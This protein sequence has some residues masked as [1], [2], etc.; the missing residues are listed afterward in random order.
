[1][2][3]KRITIFTSLLFL[4]ITLS[5][6]LQAQV[7]ILQQGFDSTSGSHA[8][9]TWTVV[10]QIQNGGNAWTSQG[11]GND[12]IEGNYSCSGWSSCYDRT[13]NTY[14]ISGGAPI[15][16][17]TGT[18]IGYGTTNSSYFAI[19]DDYDA[20]DDS[21][22]GIYTPT[23]NVSSYHNVTLTFYWNN[24][25][26]SGSYIQV[27]YKSSGS[28]SSGT[29]FAEGTGTLGWH[30]ATM[31]L[32]ATT[33][34]V[35]FF[36]VSDYKYYAIGLDQIEIY[37]TPNCTLSASISSS[38]NVSPCYGSNNGA[39]T[40]S[41]SSGTTPYTYSWTPSSGVSGATTSSASSMPEGTYTCTVTDANGCVQTPTITIGGPTKV[42]G[43]ITA[44][45]NVGCN[46]ASTGSATVAGS[47]GTSPYTYSWSSGKGTN[48][49]A[50]GLSAGS[51]TVTITDAHSCTGSVVVAITQPNV[52]RDSVSSQTNILCH[53]NS[54]GSATIGVKGGTSP[55]SYS[56]APSGGT[57]ATANNL[58]AGSYTC[59]ITDANGCTGTQAVT[60]T[61]PSLALSASISS[62]NAPCNGENGNATVTASGGT[63]P[64]SYSWTSGRGTNSTASL[65]AGN[66]TVTVTDNNGCT[67]AQSVTISQPAVLNGYYTYSNICGSTNGSISI[68]DVTGGTPPYTYT[69]TPN[70]STTATASNLTAGTYSFALNDAN[71]CGPIP[72]SQTIVNATESVSI[73]STSSVT[74]YG[75]HNGSATASA[76]P[77]HNY[78][79]SP[80]GGNSSTAN[81]LGA[82]TYTVSSTSTGGCTTT[83]TVT[84]AQPDSFA[85][86]VYYTP[87]CGSTKGTIDVQ[88]TGGTTPYTYNYRP[89]VGS[90]D[91]VYN[92]TA[93][94]YTVTVND[95]NGCGP[96]GAV[97]DIRTGTVET[98][99]IASQSNDLCNGYSDGKATASAP[100]TNYYQWSN[101]TD[102][103]A[104]DSNLTA[105]TYT[106]TG[107]N[108]TGC[109]ASTTVTITQ[110]SA[111]SASTTYTNTCSGSSNGSAQ[112]SVSGGTPPYTYSW[113]T[114]PAQTTSTATALTAGTYS[115]TVKDHNNCTITASVTIS[116]NTV[117][118][119]TV[120]PTSVS[121]CNGSSASISASGANSYAWS[122]STS[123]NSTT[124]ATVSVYPGSSITYTVTGTNSDGCS[125]TQTVSVT[126]NSL[127]TLTVTPTSVSICTGS[128]T[129]LNVSGASTYSWSPS[130]SLNV[131]TGTTVTANPTISTTYTITGTGSNECVNTQTVSVIVNSI[132]TVSVTETASVVC[133]GSPDTLKASGATTYTWMPSTGLNAT[134]GATVIAHPTTSMTYTVTG[135][136]ANGC[137]N[138]ATVI[139]TVHPTPVVNADSSLVHLI[140]GG[141]T[142]ATGG[143]PPYTYSWSPYAPSPFTLPTSPTVFVL[144]VTD[145]NGCSSKD[146]A[147]Y[148]PTPDTTGPC[149][150]IFIS[151]Y[152]Q[153]T[154]HNDDAIELYNPTPNPINLNNYYL[155]GTTNGALFYPPFKIKLSGTIGAYKTFLVANSNADTSLTNKANM[156]SDTLVYGGQDVV[157]LTHIVPTPSSA[158]VT[159]LD[160][161]GDIATPYGNNGWPVGT[162]ST[163]NY[164]LV[165]KSNIQK[166]DPNWANC[167]NEWNV[168]PR[169]TFSYI[170]H[171]SNV[172][173]PGDPVIEFVMYAPEQFCS[174]DSIRFP[175]LAN[176]T[177]E[178]RFNSSIIDFQYST[179]GFGGDNVSNGG[180]TVYPGPGFGY[181]NGDNDYN[182]FSYRS[183]PGDTI[184]EISFGDST[185]TSQ[186][187]TILPS[188]GVSGS[189]VI[190]YVTLQYQNCKTGTFSFSNISSN[191]NYYTDSI[192]STTYTLHNCDSINPDTSTSICNC[193]PCIS[194]DGS[195]DS[196]C[197]SICQT[198]VYTGYVCD[199]VWDYTY[200]TK[201]YNSTTYYGGPYY[202]T[203]CSSPSIT[204]FTTP[205][206]A[207]TGSILTINGSGFG[208]PRGSGQVEFYNADSL[209]AVST[210]MNVVDYVSWTNNQIQIKLPSWVDSIYINKRLESTIGGGNFIVKNSCGDSSASNLNL[211][212]DPFTVPYNIIQQWNTNSGQKQEILLRKLDTNGGYIFHLNPIDFPVGSYQRAIFKLA[213]QQWVCYTG[214]ALTIG[215]DTIINDTGQAVGIN[216]VFFTNNLNLVNSHTV[217]ETAPTTQTCNAFG[218][219]VL[220]RADIYF[221]KSIFFIYDTSNTFFIG[222]GQYDFYGVCLHELGH[223]L[224]LGHSKDK[225]SL[226]YYTANGGPLSPAQRIRLSTPYASAAV[227]GGLYSVGQSVL[228]SLYYCAGDSAMNPKYTYCE[229]TVGINAIMGISNNFVIYPNP[230]MGTFTIE[231]DQE[232]YD[233]SVVNMIGQYILTKRGQNGN[234]QL[235]IS[236]Q[237][238]GMYFIVIKDSKGITTKKLI[239]QK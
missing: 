157:V 60:I 64:Y 180:V 201:Q 51:Y 30:E 40:V 154:A 150:S 179:A 59:T 22:G 238:N 129:S 89:N 53:G 80:S 83:A 194:S 195:L 42:S 128:S 169:G 1:M 95:A 12:I 230:S 200:V 91:S 162:G 19:F 202:V 14:G 135:S 61:Q 214:A 193:V 21:Y 6:T 181:V 101:N 127:P 3:F 106:V 188:T 170:G 43:S 190:F 228:P 72:G 149:G 54:T 123:I 229:N 96:L 2:S 93:G 152:I 20:S 197:C 76:T 5:S 219:T 191:L 130:T 178:T 46:G 138:I 16:K 7:V 158:Q 97:V 144:T 196:M 77:T 56:W 36:I 105:G 49:S 167:Q 168:Y 37:G 73:T 171:Y 234:S 146:T 236:T 223:F 199:T 141:N 137:T 116:G 94:N 210:K 17:G 225:T 142:L 173:N 172:C 220:L 143:T 33:T 186:N 8:N 163:M 4:C 136:N 58:V 70:V 224:Q 90:T 212:G 112:V 160:K 115:V 111:L 57:H 156:L 71:G 140:T 121:L 18:N 62:A 161:I 66:Y 151:E 41:A 207:G 34:Q 68:Y 92:L 13:G 237:A 113:N 98:I 85:G 176:S 124:S 26:S 239:L 175:I 134:T 100:N 50:S 139:I 164:T 185:N 44:Q 218:Q 189:P 165:R 32:P 10:S 232:G 183:L 118:T 120:T 117:P 28:W 114:T 25:N 48:T 182:N 235:D 55:Y 231:T 145:A 87:V 213:V 132:P 166:G 29:D 119:L 39:A 23:F 82:G 88:L 38:T 27:Q 148:I 131:S 107:W 192:R 221:N 184:V 103:L 75:E 187:G 31:S 126:V 209:S 104:T 159:L 45:T 177:P 102:T 79:W 147:N 81:N 133:A 11:S 15:F 74:C 216:Y 69:W 9:G 78:T 227:D 215:S 222:A 109:W 211:N 217:A 47:G 65:P 122:P 110:P 155:G 206:N 233:I 84:I 35:V 174:G 204:D 86:E 99:S 67:T 52:I 203:P 205:V 198:V 125:A 153:D 63:T 208:N 108:N 24:A 226:M